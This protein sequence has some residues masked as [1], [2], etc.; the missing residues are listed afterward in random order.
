[1]SQPEEENV[2]D[3]QRA[4]K[5]TMALR[6]QINELMRLGTTLARESEGLPK[7]GADFE[8]YNSYPTFNT[9]MKRSEER[10]NALISKLTK[11]IGCAMRVPDVG[12]SVEHYTQ[13]VIEA[14]DNIAE[15]ASTLLETLKKSEKDEVVKVPQFIMKAAPT[16]RKT[17]AEIAAAM[18]TF[19]ANIGTV[20]AE[21]FRERREEAAQMIVHEKPQ[22][23]Y[24][25]GADNSVAPF[26]TK[27]RVKHH[28]IRK[29]TGIVIVD[30][31]E[32]GRR[33]WSSIVTETEDEHPYVAEYAHFTVAEKQ[34]K[35]ATPKKYKPLK[36]TELTMVDTKERLEALKDTLNSVEEFAV[37]VEHNEM[38]SYLG[39]TCLIQI[40]TRDQDFIVDPFPIWDHVG[41]LNEPFANPKILKV[42]HGSDNDVLWLQRDFGVHIVNLFDTYVAMKRL[43]YPKFSLAYLVLRFADVVLDKQYQLADWRARPLRNA[44]LNYAREDTHYLLYLYDMLRE[45]LLRQEEKEL[46]EVY[47]E[48]TDLCMRVYKKPVFNP[49]GY[50]TDLKFRFTLNSR[51]DYALTHLYRWRDLIARAEDESPQF[52]LPNHMLLALSETLPRDVGGIYACCNP[53]PHFVKQRTGDIFKIIVEAREVKLE[54]LEPT[55]KEVND[56]QEARGVMNDTMDHITSIL[57]SKI[58]FS[59]TRY[60]EERGE[61]DIN[62]GEESEDVKVKEY[63]DSLLSV[64]QPTTVEV[65]EEKMVVVEKGKKADRRKIARL[66]NELDS[67]VTPF[68]C[69]QMMLIAK[70]KQEEEDRKEAERKR[71]EEGDA[72]KKMFSHHDPTVNRNPE[73][74]EKLLN[75]DTIKVGSGKDTSAQPDTEPPIFDSSRFTDDQLMSKK[76]MKRKRQMARRNIDVSVVLGEGSSESKKQ[77]TDEEKQE[78]VQEVDYKQEDSTAFE[79]PIRDN[80][81]DFDP[82]HQ[83]Y[84]LKNKSKKNMTMKKSSNRQGT[85]NY[86]K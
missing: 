5:E 37:D 11:S 61:I 64:L 82:F 39:L 74:D 79:K 26:S 47:S 72:P 56:V 19:S 46:A 80:N 9:F 76:A 55:A 48:C 1:M 29:R 66:L 23:T 36:D 49:K 34:L 33:E 73:Y 22:K 62:K 14:Q 53:L 81:A 35:S 84:R 70:Q 69:Y 57:R 32:S 40:S 85:I 63:Q 54:K 4:R 30:D 17:E 75:V 59:H 31:D 21:K 38:R 41:I 60:D 65:N 24:G 12:S 45:E 78:A 68:E 2:E 6:K 7:A 16:N 8:L 86:K 10:L 51:Q 13:C 43:K 28:A 27:M 3:V 83:K 15:R 52:V 20:L 44:M 25:I 42:L 71:L 58:D 18:K 67:F 50:M 77:K